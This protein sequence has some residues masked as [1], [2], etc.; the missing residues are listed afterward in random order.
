MFQKPQKFVVGKLQ[1]A[2]EIVGTIASLSG[3]AL[4][5]V[6]GKLLLAVAFGA[7]AGGIFFRMINRRSSSQLSGAAPPPR[8]VSVAAAVL[9]VVEGAVLVE[10]TN[11]P[12][13]YSQEGFQLHHWV[14]VV[15]FLVVA[16]IVQRRVLSMLVQNRNSRPTR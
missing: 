1:V 10:A 11:L 8:W 5:V 2:L 15:V 3:A 14:L 12:V 16:F 13:R 4:A 7:L 9:S 6:F